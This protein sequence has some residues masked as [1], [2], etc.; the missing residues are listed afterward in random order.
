MTA[1]LLVL[2]GHPEDPEAFD[3]YYTTTHV[4]IAKAV[5]GLRSYTVSLGPVSTPAGPADYHR[6]ATLTWDSMEDLQAALRPPE[7]GA[8]AG[9]IAN[10]AT[11]G[12]TMLVYDDQDA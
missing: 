9:D 10:F 5:P 3:S 2:Y 4:P 6:V 1:K 11:G 12:A 8:A 7:G